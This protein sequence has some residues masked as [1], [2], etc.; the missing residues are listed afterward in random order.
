MRIVFAILCAALCQLG[1]YAH[2]QTKA[3]FGISTIGY[4][5]SPAQFP[6]V[7]RLCC[8]TTW[9]DMNPSNGTYNWSSL[10]SGLART[11][12]HPGSVNLLTLLK[13]PAWAGGSSSNNN[14]PSDIGSGDNYFKNYVT[15]LMQHLCGTSTQPPNPIVGGCSNM[16]Y[17]EMWNEFNSDGYWTG[18]DAQLATMSNDASKIIH[19]YCGDCYVVAGSVS[20]GGDGYHANGQPGNYMPALEDYLQAWGAISGA[21]LPN[22]VSFHA[23]PSRTTVTPAPFPTTIVSHSSSLCS[24]TTPSVYCRAAIKDQV[25]LVNST[26]VLKNAAISSWAASLPVLITEGGYGL[27]T[28]VCDGSDCT[29]TDV[30]VKFLRAAYAAE[31]EELL[32]AQAPAHVLWYAYNEPNWGTMYDGTTANFTYTAF[33][34]MSQWLQ[35][36]TITTQPIVSPVTGGN[37]W[38]VQGTIGG[39]QAELIFFD[40]WLSSHVYATAYGTVQTLDGSTNPTNGSVTTTQEPMLLTNHH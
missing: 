26:S 14:P 29:A 23:Y 12:G 3:D 24:T 31:W 36:M 10:D 7:V 22:A 16:R 9:T 1:Q 2:A 18:T 38:L 33:V 28:N 25:N 15:A 35:S 39:A 20:A 11:A 27:N 17:I 37:V 6:P 30:N 4:S 19:I 5:V 13:V 34:Q 40:G 21:S 8:G 32:A